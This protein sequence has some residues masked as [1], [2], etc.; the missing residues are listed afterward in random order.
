MEGA[1]RPFLTLSRSAINQQIAIRTIQKLGFRVTAAWNGRQALD[2]LVAAQRGK[3]TKPA[4][5]LMDVQM[6]V[7]DGYKCTHLMRHHEPYRRYVEDIPIVAMTASAIQGDREKCREAG[8]DDYL[9]KPVKS[10]TLER[11]LVQW[12]VARRRAPALL[13]ESDPECP[14]DGERC[15]KTNIPVVD[16]DE[17]V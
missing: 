12:C 17:H 5:I 11:M 6:P 8:M 9:A 16:V 10:L 15:S 14:E 4:I 2:Y 7:I 13:E 3:E 1:G